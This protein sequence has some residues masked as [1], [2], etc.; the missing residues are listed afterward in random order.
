[1]ADGIR[2]LIETAE[3]QI[4]VNNAGGGGH[5]PPHFSDATPEQWSVTLYLNLVAPM[6][7]TQ[8]ALER[9]LVNPFVS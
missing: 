1:M 7:A 3:P 5:I 2:R 4:L 9:N 6:L 8:L